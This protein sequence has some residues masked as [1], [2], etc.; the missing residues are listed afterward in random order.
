MNLDTKTLEMTLYL[1]YFLKSVLCR[2]S[3]ILIVL[4]KRNVKSGIHDLLDN[5]FNLFEA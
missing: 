1:K 2:E 3:D 4:F 5:S